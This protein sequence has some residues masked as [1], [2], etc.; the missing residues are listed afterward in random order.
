MLP[1]IV[2]ALSNLREFDDNISGD[3]GNKSVF[4]PTELHLLSLYHDCNNDKL[5]SVTPDYGFF[6][7]NLEKKQTSIYR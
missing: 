1:Y 7:C 6:R 3:F 5:C 4:L 2:I